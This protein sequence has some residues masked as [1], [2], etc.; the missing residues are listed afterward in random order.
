MMSA[1]RRG[2]RVLELAAQFAVERAG[3]AAANEEIKRDEAHQ[4]RVLKSAG[5]PEEPLGRG[6][7]DG[8]EHEDEDRE[9]DR[10]GEQ[11]E[12]EQQSPE[13]LGQ[14]DDDHPEQA[15]LVPDAFE[16]GGETSK[17]CAAKPA[18]QLLA[19]VR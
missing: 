3:A 12:H 7:P 19:P 11:A 5:G 18:E 2:M 4:E 15:R 10:A 1:R 13:R 17:A 8:V 9:R 16:D 6:D 14:S